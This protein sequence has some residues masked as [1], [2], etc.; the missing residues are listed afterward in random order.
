MECRRYSGLEF[1]EDPQTTGALLGLKQLTLGRAQN[2]GHC[3]SRS[4]FMRCN[5]FNY[6]HPP[7]VPTIRPSV[8]LSA[9]PCRAVISLETFKTTGRHTRRAGD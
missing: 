8:C 3:H 2:P 1:Y 4:H 7:R 6:H 9:A 5:G